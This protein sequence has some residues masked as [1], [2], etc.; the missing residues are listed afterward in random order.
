[1]HAFDSPA[2]LKYRLPLIYYCFPKKLAFRLFLLWVSHTLKV[3][4]LTEK[5]HSQS[6]ILD[7]FLKNIC[8]ATL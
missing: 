4:L 7:D 8:G 1:M 5:K 2:S 6:V 3:H